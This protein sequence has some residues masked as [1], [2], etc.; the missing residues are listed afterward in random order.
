MRKEDFIPAIVSE[1]QKANDKETINFDQIELE[2]HVDLNIDIIPPETAI[3]VKN[4]IWGTLGNFSVVMGKA[5]SKK[6]FLVTAVIAAASGNQLILGNLQGTLP[7]N[8]KTILWF[9]TEQGRHHVQRA[10]RR[11][12]DLA[13]IKKTDVNLKVYTLRSYNTDTRFAFIDHLIMKSE[14][15]GIVVIDGTRDIL[16]DINSPDEA[17]TISDALL[18]WTETKN[19]HIITVLHA[20]K[21]D[22]NLRGHIGTEL[23]NKAEAIID[24]SVDKKDKLISIVSCER[25]RNREFEEFAF[26]INDHALPENCDMPIAEEN[27]KK[28]KPNG[29]SD[30]AHKEMINSIWEKNEALNTT[31]LWPQIQ[32][33][34][35]ERDWDIGRN[36]VLPFIQYWENKK[37]IKNI[38]IGRKNQYSSII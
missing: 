36:L 15:V 10:A 20:N 35:S 27:R 21:T 13:G 16:K 29:L 30:D 12:L 3:E 28:I 32:F 9:D 14:G 7:T 5:K 11:A 4:E 6:T 26:R 31:Q 8:K 33:Q 23:L 24:V 1:A 17:T 2:A 19:I 25:S 37:W 22:A 34:L 38:A 18:R